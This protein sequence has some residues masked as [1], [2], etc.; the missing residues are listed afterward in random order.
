PGLPEEWIDFEIDRCF[1]S[2]PNSIRI[3]GHHAEPI[4]PGAQIGVAGLASHP[5]A[6]PAGI[7]PVEAV[8]ETDQLRSRKAQSRVT[9]CDPAAAC[10]KAN[11]AAYGNIGSVRGNGLYLSHSRS[12]V[13]LESFRVHNRNAAIQGEPDA[14]R[15][16]RHHRPESPHTLRAAK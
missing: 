9:E 11:G 10:R 4:A 1:F 8:A 6:A 13:A 7:I 2:I 14:A 12:R 16:I 3:A 5:R 15:E